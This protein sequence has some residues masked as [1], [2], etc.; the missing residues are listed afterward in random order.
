MSLKQ[1]VIESGGGPSYDWSNDHIR[2][3][4]TCDHA[5]GRVTMVED[6]LKPG[7]CLACHYHK[8]MTEIFYI[9]GGEVTFKFEDETVVATRGMTIN[10]PPNVIHEVTSEKGARLLTVFS[11]GG[12]DKY[13]E[14]MAAMTAE[15]FA[16]AALM[17]KLS[18]QYDTWMV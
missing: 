14:E 12:F 6:T 1:Q 13:L 10:I 11:P 5:E 4:T 7:F 2:V 8:K 17:K 16:D 9:L 18:E 15:Q 3:K